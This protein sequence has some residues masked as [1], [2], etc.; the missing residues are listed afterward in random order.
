M[1]EKMKFFCFATLLIELKVNSRQLQ[2][3]Q[4]RAAHVTRVR[5]GGLWFTERND[6]CWWCNRLEVW[7]CF[8]LRTLSVPLANR[9]KDRNKATVNSSSLY[10]SPLA[11]L[12]LLS[13]CSAISHL[14]TAGLIPPDDTYVVWAVSHPCYEHR[15]CGKRHQR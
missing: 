7:G 11:R 8:A 3:W 2:L 4:Q 10:L 6:R 9:R 14:C 13:P 5:W 15:S 1:N 12:G